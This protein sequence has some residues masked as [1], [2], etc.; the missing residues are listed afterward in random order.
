MAGHRAGVTT[1][2][3]CPDGKTLA[4]ADGDALIKLSDLATGEQLLTLDGLPGGA[5]MLRFSADGK[6]LAAI[7]SKDGNQPGAIRVWLAADSVPTAEP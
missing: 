7:G 2:P 3:F 6:A 1:L 5:W 4:S